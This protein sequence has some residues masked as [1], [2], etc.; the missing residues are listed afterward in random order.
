MSRSANYGPLTTT[1]AQPSSCSLPIALYQSVTVD[2][3]YPTVDTIISGVSCV[4]NSVKVCTTALSGTSSGS[5]ICSETPYYTS[6]IDPACYPPVSMSTDAE[7]FNSWG[8]YSPGLVCPEGYTTAC[9]T[10]SGGTGDW[11][12]IWPLTSGET[13]AGCCP[14]SAT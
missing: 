2:E 14:R 4:S 11:D 10:T 8:Y 12:P 3:P 13:A 5:T 6:T 1:W 7:L 9:H